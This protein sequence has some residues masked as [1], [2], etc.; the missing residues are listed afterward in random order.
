MM[1]AVTSAGAS[2]PEQVARELLLLESL[3]SLLAAT[4]G[5]LCSGD[6]LPL[7]ET[8]RQIHCVTGELIALSV[9]LSR[10][11]SSSDQQ[12][13]RRK[14]I[15]ELGQQRAFCRAMLRRWRRS[16]ALRSQLLDMRGEPVPYTESLGPQPV[17]P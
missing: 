4:T 17:S 11:C 5:S 8:S 13:Q 12:Q 14:L 16:I 15:L 6:A 1:T 9:Q 10:T 3:R 2:S 7:L